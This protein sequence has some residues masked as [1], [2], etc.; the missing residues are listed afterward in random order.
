MSTKVC[1]L[2]VKIVGIC[3]PPSDDKKLNGDFT[4]KGRIVLYVLGRY[5]YAF[6]SFMQ[7]IPIGIR[8]RIAGLPVPAK[9]GSGKGICDVLIPGQYPAL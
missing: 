5:S 4:I 3:V 8:F 6:H 9:S 1:W 7:S 2:D